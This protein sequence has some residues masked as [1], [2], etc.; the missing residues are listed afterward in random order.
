M[1]LLLAPS[2]VNTMARQIPAY[3]ENP[4]AG[5]EDPNPF[6][7]FFRSSVTVMRLICFTL[8]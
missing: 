3:H 7:I 6:P 5:A 1:N 2:R 4:A 8:L